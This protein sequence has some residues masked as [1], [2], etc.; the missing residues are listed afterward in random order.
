MEAVLQSAQQFFELDWL[1]HI[2]K[3]CLPDTCIFESLVTSI[4]VISKSNLY[5]KHLSFNC[6]IPLWKVL[7]LPIYKYI[8]MSNQTPPPF[9]PAMCSCKNLILVIAVFYFL[10]SVIV[11]AMSPL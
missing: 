2:K 7:Y 4:K 5:L 3:Q 11:I 1:N 9:V 8:F 10:T 6:V